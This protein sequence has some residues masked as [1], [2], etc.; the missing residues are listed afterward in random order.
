V[1]TAAQAAD[2]A[3]SPSP[4]TKKVSHKSAEKAEDAYIEGARQLRDANYEA[5]ERSFLRAYNLNP[6]KNEYL[7]ALSASRERHLT[8]LVQQSSQARM[9]NHT[10]EADR[11][12]TQARTLDPS[13]PLIAEHEIVSPSALPHVDQVAQRHFILASTIEFAPAKDL[14]SFH[15]RGDLRA[16]LQHV[17]MAYG[18]KP[19]FE[20]DVP[21]KNI[22]LDVD[23]I[24]FTSAL[25]ITQMMTSVFYTPLDAKTAIVAKDNPENRERL[26]L[27]V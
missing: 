5:A 18:I 15:E 6:E 11:L 25:T 9:A 10:E 27:L 23:D 20:S 26:E 14:H 22:R 17:L 1:P 3:V 2:A 8:G 19:T 12:L 24:D 4:S 13:N 7:L 16:V 21:A